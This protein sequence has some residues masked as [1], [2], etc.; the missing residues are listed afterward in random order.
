M[1]FFKN[2]TNDN[3]EVHIVFTPRDL[4]N[5]NFDGTVLGERFQEFLNDNTPEYQHSD[6]AE[7]FVRELLKPRYY[8]HHI[9][10]SRRLSEI[11]KL[12]EINKD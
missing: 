7:Y 8:D 2:R 3:L 5:K 11:E 9:E 10:R 6:T 4:G 1:L 12:L